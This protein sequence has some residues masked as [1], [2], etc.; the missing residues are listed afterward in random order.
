MT[1]LELAKASLATIIRKGSLHKGAAAECGY[2]AE[3][4][5]EDIEATQ[6]DL[7]ALLARVKTHHNDTVDRDDVI[8]TLEVIL[9]DR[10]TQRRPVANPTAPQAKEQVA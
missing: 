1:R 10:L 2:I 5:T 8:A 3:R 6:R 7:S 4:V 9:L